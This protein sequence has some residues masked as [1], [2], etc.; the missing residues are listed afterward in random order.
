MSNPTRATDEE[1]EDDETPKLALL[2]PKVKSAAVQANPSEDASWLSQTTIDWSKCQQTN[3]QVRKVLD[4]VDRGHV[5]TTQDREQL[6]YSGKKIWCKRERSS[7]APENPTGQSTGAGV[8]G[9]ANRSREYGDSP[10]DA[11]EKRAH[12]T[13]E[14]VS[15]VLV[16][17]L[18]SQFPGCSTQGVLRV[19]K[20]SAR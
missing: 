17:L 4:W 18:P 3:L 8:A 13:L 11:G 14:D 20:L 9:G 6:T 15:L 19:P 1:K 5:Y 16:Q 10:V 7:A 2:C 12:W